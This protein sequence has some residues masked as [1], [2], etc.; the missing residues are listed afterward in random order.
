ME[1]HAPYMESFEK[2][3]FELRQI[4]GIGSEQELNELY[5]RH[6][7]FQNA[8]TNPKEVWFEKNPIGEEYHTHIYE[9]KHEGEKTYYIIV[10]SYFDEAPSFVF[11]KSLTRS[12]ELAELYRKGGVKKDLDPK[13]QEASVKFEA[14]PHD[15]E[16][17]GPEVEI[18]QDVLEDLDL[19]KSEYLATLLEVR[20]DDD[21]SFETFSDYDE[22]LPL[23]IEDP[24]EIYS[25]EDEAGDEVHT[26]IK[27]FQAH[28]IPFFYV[29]ICMKVD[30]SQPKD[31][32]ALLPV[33]SFPSKD[34]GLYK[35]YAVGERIS[36]MVKN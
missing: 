35:D 9:F 3:E 12:K 16:E 28:G 20:S 10:C 21:I 6:D 31:H 8:L 18:P 27:S 22:Y 36:S 23:T 34:Q 13:S 26:Y 14:E 5:Q 19:K 25:K 24:D 17:K 1:F 2:E 30:I 33:L 15:E 4:A 11:F 32:E 29:V 7:I